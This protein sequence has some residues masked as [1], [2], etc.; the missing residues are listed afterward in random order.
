VIDKFLREARVRQWQRELTVP[1][2]SEAL[3]ADPADPAA[4]TADRS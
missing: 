2:L 3:Y 4:E 1:V